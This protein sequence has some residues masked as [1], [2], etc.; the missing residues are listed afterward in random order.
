LPLAL[1]INS[2]HQKTKTFSTATGIIT[3]YLRMRLLV[4]RGFINI[5]PI[6]DSLSTAAYRSLLSTA[7]DLFGQLI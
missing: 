7:N 2:A 5:Y 4:V 3:T 1:L 6:S